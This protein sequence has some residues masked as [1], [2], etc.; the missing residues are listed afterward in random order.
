MNIKGVFAVASDKSDT[1]SAVSLEGAN[2]KYFMIVGLPT[3]REFIANEFSGKEGAEASVIKM[4]KD[5]GVVTIATGSQR[6]N[7]SKLMSE[8][9]IK[10]YRVTGKIS[11]L[12]GE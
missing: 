10:C 7:F 3:G 6:E 4:L 1:T 5:K 2:A 8:N 9:G 11:M 12:L